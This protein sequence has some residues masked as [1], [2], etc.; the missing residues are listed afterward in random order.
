MPMSSLQQRASLG[1]PPPQPA[2]ST[3]CTDDGASSAKN[4]S[5]PKHSFES[6]FSTGLDL[7]E[8]AA[9][10]NSNSS[11]MIVAASA[12]LAQQ[13][14]NAVEQQNR[15]EKA[16]IIL[17]QRVANVIDATKH[18]SATNNYSIHDQLGNVIPRAINPH[19]E[20]AKANHDNWD[21]IMNSSDDDDAIIKGRSREDNFVQFQDSNGAGHEFLSCLVS[22]HKVE[23]EEGRISSSHKARMTKKK[24]QQLHKKKINSGGRQHTANKKMSPASGGSSRRKI[25]AKKKSRKLKY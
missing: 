22:N 18:N 12:D 25:V 5:K 10:N 17:E 1:A 21:D 23:G 20:A 16:E 7:S 6:C 3:L 8:F 4:N 24:Q 11:N 13:K 19:N 15:E 9:T 2:K 14:R